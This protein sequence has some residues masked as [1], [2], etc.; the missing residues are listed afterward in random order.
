MAGNLTTSRGTLN[1]DRLVVV[2]NFQ[3]G[4]QAHDLG[5]IRDGESW[6]TVDELDKARGHHF[7]SW[8]YLDTLDR[9]PAPGS[10][11]KVI[12]EWLARPDESPFPPLDRQTQFQL[13]AMCAFQA[14]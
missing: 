14:P 5:L 6:L 9:P 13:D 1:A 2:P 10:S 12:E 4:K 3:F 7:T 8:R 11:E